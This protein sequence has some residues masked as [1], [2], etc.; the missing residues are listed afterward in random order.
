MLSCF[1]QYQSRNHT[2]VLVD[3]SL[4]SPFPISFFLRLYLLKQP[5][6]CP[7][8]FPHFLCWILL[9]DGI[10]AIGNLLALFLFF[11]RTETGL[12][13][14]RPDCL[15]LLSWR[16]VG[17]ERCVT[18]GIHWHQEAHDAC[19]VPSSPALVFSDWQWVQVLSGYCVCV[20]PNEPFDCTA[21]REKRIQEGV[22]GALLRWLNI[23]WVLAAPMH[24]SDTMA[25]VY[26]LCWFV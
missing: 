6:I 14:F 25:L 1:N 16:R 9:T 12:V 21:L 8:E 13:R 18:D 24:C 20:L 7:V 3:K 26:G 11:L 22:W 15:F 2:I 19:C 17:H 10:T 5:C 23:R 4:K